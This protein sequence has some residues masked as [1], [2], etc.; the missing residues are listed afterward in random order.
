MFSELIILEEK[1]EEN[2][3]HHL[4]L[5]DRVISWTLTDDIL[6]GYRLLS[7]LCCFQGENLLRQPLLR[8]TTSESKEKCPWCQEQTSDLTRLTVTEGLWT[9]SGVLHSQ[10]RVR[11]FPTGGTYVY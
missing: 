9:A 11:K 6:G 1:E 7:V 10:C 3:W 8:T 2:E 5:I 4:Q